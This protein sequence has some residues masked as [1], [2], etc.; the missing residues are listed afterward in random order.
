LVFEA[1]LLQL[2]LQLLVFIARAHQPDVFIPAIGDKIKRA[3]ETLV[4]RRDRAHRPSS[5]QRHVVAATHL[6]PQQ[7][8]LKEHRQ[9]Q[10][11]YVLVMRPEAHVSVSVTRAKP[12]AA[13]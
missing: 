4:D 10:G 2:A 11:G 6:V 3:V 7:H 13:G 5:Q 9:D 1:R 8:K 12:A